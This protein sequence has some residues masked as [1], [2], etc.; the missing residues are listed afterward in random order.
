VTRLLVEGDQQPWVNAA[1]RRL[2]LGDARFVIVT[3]VRPPVGDILARWESVVEAAARRLPA[4]RFVLVAEGGLDVRVADSLRD[5]AQVAADGI[6]SATACHAADVLMQPESDATDALPVM[7]AAALRVP[8]V[9]AGAGALPSRVEAGRSGVHV[10]PADATA[11]VEALKALYDAPS[12]REQ[13]GARAR[14]YAVRLFDRDLANGRILQV[15]DGLLSGPQP[16]KLTP[17]GRLVG[18]NER[19]DLDEATRRVRDLMRRR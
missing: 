14:Q 8:A 13:M 6:D 10:A 1:R 11:M 19:T 9:V 7:E 15:Y 5:R 4:A 3:V 16:A 17:D 2:G 18:A 12:E